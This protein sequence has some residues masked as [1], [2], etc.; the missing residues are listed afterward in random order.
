M[1][2]STKGRYGIRALLELAVHGASG[3]AVPLSVIAEH[4]DI[5]EG[6]LEQ[7]MA[8]LRKAGI[9]KG[10]KGPQGG[11]QLAN[12]PQMVA[13][14]KVLEILEGDLFHIDEDPSQTSDGELMQL[15]I[16]QNLWEPMASA[17]R[18]AIDSV[19]LKDLMDRYL[20]MRDA[21]AMMYY[22]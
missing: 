17:L 16:S 5:S 7:I 12:P 9:V 15:C 21:S 11:Y 6:Y 13:I 22:I 1:N 8:S 14:L 4:Q 3:Q 2:I 20:Q 19:T 18:E 10:I